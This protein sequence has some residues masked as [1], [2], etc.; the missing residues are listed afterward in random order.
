MLVL[1]AKAGFFQ[2]F[3]VFFTH[4]GALLLIELAVL[5]CVVLFE[6]FLAESFLLGIE[7]VFALA[8]ADRQGSCTDEHGNPY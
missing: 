1:W 6:H 2:P 5:V 4:F 7:I 8:R 3:P